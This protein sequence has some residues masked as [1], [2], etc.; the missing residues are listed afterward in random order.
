R[1]GNKLAIKELSSSYDFL[2]SIEEHFKLEAGPGS[3]KTTFIANHVKR[4]LLE[5]ER[6]KKTRKVACITYTNTGVKALQERLG[7]AKHEVEVSTI[8]SFLY[9]HV[10]KPYFWLLKDWPFQNDSIPDLFKQRLHGGHV[11]DV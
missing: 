3:G 5:S 7:D 9:K 1:G 6:L 11:R 4:I 8:H 10:L 2:E